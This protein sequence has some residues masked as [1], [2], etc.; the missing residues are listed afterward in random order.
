[1]NEKDLLDQIKKSAEEITPP[2][3]L[4]PENIEA[5]LNAAKKTVSISEHSSK[6]KRFSVYRLGGIA[7]VFVLALVGL[8][9]ANHISSIKSNESK[10]QA[11]ETE[12]AETATIVSKNEEEKNSADISMQS[13]AAGAADTSQSKSDEAELF[14][15]AD[16]SGNAAEDSAEDSFSADTASGNAAEDSAEDSFSATGAA[17]EAAED[18]SADSFSTEAASGNV[19]EDSAEDSF[20]ADAASGN[21]VQSSAE[22]SFSADAASGNA[23]EDS[24]TDS[25]SATGATGNTS[26]DSADA[27]AAGAADNAAQD[28]AT[29][30]FSAA[31]A[32]ANTS[33][34]SADASA[35]DTPA[36]ASASAA[37][38]LTTADS[39]QALYDTLYKKFGGNQ[40]D[41]V[42]GT[43]EIAEDAAGDVQTAS[44]DISLY[45]KSDASG[46][47]GNTY[48]E[49]N[50]QELGVD[51]GDFVKTDG[52]CIYILKRSGQMLIVSA[53]QGTL[54]LL[55]TTN[56][57]MDETIQEMYL[58]G[59]QL[60]IITSGYYTELNT[61]IDDVYTAR[62]TN[63]T[64]LYTYDISDRKNPVLTGTVTQDGSYRTSRKNGS[65]I[66][67][68][69]QYSPMIQDTYEN[70][71]IV[72][73]TSRGDLSADEIYLPDNL[74][75]STYLVIS[76]VSLREP[77]QVLDQKAVV[78]VAADFYVSTENIY[79]TNE[80]W[81][82]GDTHTELV[83]LHYEDGTITGTAAGSVA[84]YLNNSFS[85]NEYN[86]YLRVVSTSYDADYNETNA[87]YVL[88]EN[89][90]LVGAIK[91]LAPDETIRSARFLQ[92][93]GYFVTFRQ[94][95][96]LFSVDLSDP[97]N[98]KILGDL[99][100]SGFS[101]YLHFYS[102]NLL[103]GLGYEANEDTGVT[104]GLKLSM[105]D[106]SDPSNVKEVSRLVLNGIT[107]CDSLDD[108]KSI[109]IDP[110]KNIFGFTCDNRY[111]LF[112]YDEE[113]GFTKEFIY[114]FYNDIIEE[115]LNENPTGDTTSETDA[116]TF[117]I[118]SYYLN[119]TA[120]SDDTTTRGLYINDTL[121]LVR[122][123]A[124]T[125]FD[126]KDGYRETG[127]LSF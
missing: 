37:F 67:L 121:Y 23:A 60:S 2:D 12:S 69:T 46:P 68:F 94:T 78:S 114:D 90:K 79:I 111:L 29:D 48:S 33:E 105:F 50:I 47:S 31:G 107:W 87:L 73:S 30:S 25:F 14:A 56:F 49:T 88:D 85:L 83:K 6:K 92:N 61:E 84:G 74:N 63:R 18:S 97:A 125:A 118:A 13:K 52:N 100:V 39:Y 86:G 20:S 106:I 102:N 15:A 103:L 38:A 22:D 43:M 117:D 95:D 110:A 10:T 44:T 80:N 24:A 112:S 82:D 17:D 28:S 126:M 54:N 19:A 65:Y 119:N 99:K 64:H 101:S 21:A 72:P 109:L 66:Y 71:R 3:S 96:P 104:T 113:K 93:I 32:T 62:S 120:Y 89:L 11:V 91:D 124:I 7:A 26:E 51:E 108:Y 122:P 55:S 98:P 1:M 34:D 57:S 35:S 127:R 123:N 5:Q 116:A 8:W 59:D 58:D 41:L 81:S 9:Q 40:S 4:K 36:A 77:G 45:A 42:Y 75:Y 115:S 76:S 70:S 27:S 16:A 53:D